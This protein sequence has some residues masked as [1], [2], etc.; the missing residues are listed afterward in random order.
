MLHG[1]EPVGGVS[2]ACN[3]HNRP[4]NQFSLLEKSQLL[5]EP[6]HVHSLGSLVGKA[7]GL[8]SRVSWVRIPPEAANF[9]WKKDFLRQVELLCLVISKFD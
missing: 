4:V 8:E 5:V 2:A 3:K 7:V 9:L 1:V 6:L